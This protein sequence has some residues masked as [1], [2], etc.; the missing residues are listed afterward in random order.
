MLIYKFDFYF[1]KY[2]YFIKK[3][4][5]TQMSVGIV[6][7]NEIKEA[8]Y[9]MGI[10]EDKDELSFIDFSKCIQELHTKKLGE[11]YSG[12]VLANS[13]AETANKLS[14]I[15]YLTYKKPDQH[16][17]ESILNL[18]HTMVYI[19]SLQ[20]IKKSNENELIESANRDFKPLIR[21]HWNRFIE[22]TSECI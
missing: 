22:L 16:F 5:D 15:N 10:G 19:L 14:N 13:Y 11:N 4:V 7:L 18:Y 8:I 1:I 20:T 17:I 6:T 21:K 9:S 3:M 2:C 12:T